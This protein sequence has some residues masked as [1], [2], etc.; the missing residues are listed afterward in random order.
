ML[1]QN[2]RPMIAEFG[3]HNCRTWEQSNHAPTSKRSNHPP[4]H[5][6]TLNCRSRGCLYIYWTRFQQ[7]PFFDQ[8]RCPVTSE[9]KLK[10]MNF[11]SWRS[12]FHSLRG[13]DLMGFVDGSVPCPS[14]DR[15]SGWGRYHSVSPNPTPI[16]FDRIRCCCMLSLHQSQNRACLFQHL[17]SKTS[18]EA[19]TKLGKLLSKLISLKSYE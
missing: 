5:R 15:C 18:P 14:K 19:Q 13:Y 12:Q 1:N 6:G 7:R 4:W 8:C 10:P 17:S 9:T 3:A 11:P 2:V 16:G